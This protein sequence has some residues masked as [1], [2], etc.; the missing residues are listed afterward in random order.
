MN[1][2]ARADIATTGVIGVSPE[3]FFAEVSGLPENLLMDKFEIQSLSGTRKGWKGSQYMAW[4]QG[5]LRLHEKLWLQM[6]WSLCK[7][8]GLPHILIGSSYKPAW[9][10]FLDAYGEFLNEG[11]V[12]KIKFAASLLARPMSSWLTAWAMKARNQLSRDFAIS[13]R[14]SCSLIWMASIPQMLKFKTTR[15]AIWC[16]KREAYTVLEVKNP[17]SYLK[18]RG[19]DFQ[20]GRLMRVD[21]GRRHNLERKDKR[22]DS[23]VF[24]YTYTS[25]TSEEVYRV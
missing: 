14:N 24:T 10:E 3:L 18:K 7:E 11:E 13:S 22:Y 5:I 6:M 15:T 1:L 19:F 20:Q 17:F 25:L 9:D 21:Y 8:I 2:L 4:T 23:R 12:M 16:G